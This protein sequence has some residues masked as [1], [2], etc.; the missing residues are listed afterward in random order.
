MLVRI[1]QSQ[2]LWL[3]RESIDL[4]I[5]DYDEL[6]GLSEQETNDYISANARN[7]NAPSQ[8]SDNYE[9]LGEC[10]EDMDLIRDKETDCESHIYFE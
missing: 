8:C 6:K 7:M 10:P 1:C 5:E 3:T 9:T 2:N 4:N